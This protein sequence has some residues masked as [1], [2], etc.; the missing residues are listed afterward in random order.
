MRGGFSGA[1]DFP[2]EALMFSFRIGIVVLAITVTLDM[3]HPAELH[4]N[5]LMLLFFASSLGGMAIGRVMP[6]EGTSMNGSK[7][8][9]VIAV[10][11]AAVV[12][13]G[14]LFSALGHN[15]LFHISRPIITVLSWIGTVVIYVI[16]FPI[17]YLA[18]FI[19]KGLRWLIGEPVAR[20]EQRVLPSEMGLGDSL[21]QLMKDAEEKQ[22]SV[23]IEILEVAAIFIGVI[24]LLAIFAFAFR[25]RVRWGRRPFEKDRS[26][27]SQGVNPL[28]DMLRLAK[29]LIPGFGFRRPS[30]KYRIPDTVDEASR[31]IL[32]SY[33][34]MLDKGNKKGV[35]R[36]LDT[37]PHEIVPVLSN[38]L[39]P[40][41]VIGITE[42]FVCVCYGSIT[43]GLPDVAKAKEML[44]N[45][46]VVDD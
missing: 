39:A 13:L 38:V 3:F 1:A 37:T 10:L 8:A 2:M 25:R 29:S 9:Q 6:A 27:L 18:E 32:R 26:S 36:K 19:I 40:Q 15:F 14:A 21:Q 45:L 30:P 16:V 4:L 44:K 24:G 7:W 22:P 34:E 35:E 31:E 28:E 43:I 42:L 11:I 20:E 5:M 41:S 33:Y 17:A 46:E 12:S 23:F